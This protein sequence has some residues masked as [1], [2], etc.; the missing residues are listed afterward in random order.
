[1]YFNSPKSLLLTFT[2]LI[3][4]I[5]I[6]IEKQSN[7]VINMYSFT[8]LKAILIIISITSIGINILNINPLR[9]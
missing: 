3:M 2:M 7:L 9:L 1:M 8:I 4:N 6:D 5:S